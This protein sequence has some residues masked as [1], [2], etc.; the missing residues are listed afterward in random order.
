[1]EIIWSIIVIMAIL[2]LFIGYVANQFG[3]NKLE[4]SLVAV[5][6]TALAILSFWW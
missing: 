6:G 2:G 3:L 1:M 4:C 5:G